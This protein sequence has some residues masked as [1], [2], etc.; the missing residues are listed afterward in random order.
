MSKVIKQME[1]DT[2]KQ[3]FKDV[4]DM[5]LISPKGVSAGLDHGLRNSL[6]KKKIRVMMVKNTL[7]RR[8]FSEL[9]MNIAKDSPYWQNTT[10]MIWGADSVAELSKEVDAAV[11]NDPKFK[12]KFVV[13]GAIAEG[14]AITFD[15]AKTLP[16]RAEALSRV[17][18]LILGPGSQLASAIIGPGGQLAGQ[19]KSLGD[20]KDEEAAAPAA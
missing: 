19:V 5:V 17:A 2:L 15:L 14:S 9:G 18:A 6:R 11:V 4:R 3:T 8:V 1:M 20:K 7:T 13:K 12:D 16:T 10:W